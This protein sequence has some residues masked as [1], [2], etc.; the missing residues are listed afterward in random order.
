MTRTLLV[1]L[2]SA[3]VFLAAPVGAADAAAGKANYDMLCSVCHGPTGK[4]DGPAG[5]ALTPPPRDFSVGEFKYDADKNGTPGEDA[6]LTLIIKNGAAAYGGNPV[7]APWG[8][9]AD[10]DLAN[11]VAF[12][13][14]LKQ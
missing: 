4:G 14:T 11:L 1:L 9:L 12:I 2:A 13:R 3:F 7:M 6:D 5:V 10:A 8:H